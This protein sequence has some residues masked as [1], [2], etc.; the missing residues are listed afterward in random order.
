MNNSE[1]ISGFEGAE[2]ILHVKITSPK[3]N[4]G[5]LSIPQSK[6]SEI[7]TVAKCTIL[8]RICTEYDICG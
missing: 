3:P 7:L 8:S 4:N 5:L 1:V 2:K 6:W